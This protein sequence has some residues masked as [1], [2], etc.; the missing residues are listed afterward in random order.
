MQKPSLYLVITH[1]PTYLH[2]YGP[3]SYRIGYQGETKY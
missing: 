3:I 2:I 1:F